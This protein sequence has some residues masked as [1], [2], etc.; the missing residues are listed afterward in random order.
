MYE[1]MMIYFDRCNPMF[2][3]VIFVNLSLYLK[4][5]KI[6]H[7]MYIQLHFV[8]NNKNFKIYFLNLKFK[9]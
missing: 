6:D 1:V 2:R 3:L 7:F 4:L 5:I 8:I 9:P